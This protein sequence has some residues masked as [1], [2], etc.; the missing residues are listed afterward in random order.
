MNQPVFM[1]KSKGFLHLLS[2]FIRPYDVP[3]CFRFG[4][5]QKTV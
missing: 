3:L 2:T 1:L 5:Y 4:R